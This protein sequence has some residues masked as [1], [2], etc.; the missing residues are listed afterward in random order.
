MNRQVP[1]PP[2]IAEALLRWFCSEEVV[3]TLLGDLYELH[4]KR[5][6]ALGKWR[7]DIYF[8]MEVVDLFRPFAWKKKHNLITNYR[9]LFKL[10]LKIARRHFLKQK[11]FTLINIFGL[12]LG[13]SSFLLILFYV[14]H[15]LSFDRFHVNSDQVFRVNCSFQDNAGNV[16]T[17]V[18]SPPALAPGIRGRF[19]ELEKI[20]RLRYTQNCLLSNEGVHFYEDRGYY[21]DSVFLEILQFE[22]LSGSPTTALVQPNSVVITEDMALKYFDDPAP[23]G[24][25]LLLN[26]TISLEVT[27]ILANLP[28]NSHLN[29]DFLI[30]FPTYIVPEG[31]ASDL[32]SWGW[33]G[34]LTYVKLQPNTDPEQFE[35]GL[36]NYFEELN[37]DDPSP[38][39]PI[40]QNMSDIYLGSVD[41]TDDLASHIRSGNRFSM[42]AL[43]IVAIL[44]LLIAGFNFSNLSQALSVNR[45]KS[46]GIRKVLGADGKS[47]VF[48]LVIE[49]L[50][51]TFFSLLLSI[52]FVYLVF[53]FVSRFANWEFYPGL[54]E[55]QK[56]VPVM[57]AAGI[58]IGILSSF[59]PALGFAKMN[60]VKSLKGTLKTE[61][62]SPLQF[63]NVLLT[64]QFAISIS[65]ICASLI[66]FKQINYLRNTDTGYTSENVVV[67]KTLPEDMSRFYKLYKD[68][69]VQHSSVLQV[70][71]SE[72][73]IG[74]PWPFSV[75]RNVDEGPEMNKRIFFNQV[76]YDYFTTMGVLMD[77]GRSFSKEY[78]NDSTQAIIVN[79]KA[80][81][82][83]ELENPIG[84]QVHFF[85]LDGPR[86]IVGVVEDFNYT[87]LHQELGPAAIILP[88]IDLEY[89][90]VRF[91]PGN[92]KN[93]IAILE[94][95]WQQ[96]T[97]GTPLEWKFMDADLE[98]LYHSEEKLSSMI[99]AFSILAILL[100]CLGLYGIVAFMVSKRIK[101]VGIRKVLGASVFSLYSLFIKTY[102]YQIMVATVVTLPLTHHLLNGW[103]ENFAYHIRIP[104][105]VYPTAALLLTLITLA[106]ITF[107]ILNAARVNPSRLIR[108]E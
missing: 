45:S 38:I 66:I 75:I 86:T 29:F 72:R 100:A 96:L 18:N 40:V 107:Q 73:V 16:T 77:S 70:S 62:R 93:Q 56:V 69:L 84:E 12:T 64:L 87:S 97:T 91:H 15:E 17:L 24:E 43:M 57:I 6:A 21:A 5:T 71:R 52:G 85:E 80:V 79:Q 67:I 61:T 28:A 33:L 53:P 58:F 2:G 44:V 50:L 47:I 106:A 39:R 23:L 34:F 78:M 31:Y 37:P 26:N 68:R 89:M 10:S 103:L 51:L 59:Y 35:A 25:T 36:A 7:A 65:L 3:E 55:I 32:S 108:Q 83:L 30:S 76:D 48:Q 90:Y 42:K 14:N 92:P 82:L 19:P 46:T 81:G 95:T 22:L 20:S 74:D 11:K 9:M 104:W 41:M 102:I 4:G 94:D 88:F 13:L 98:S 1:K 101:E 54:I 105:W 49:S 99:Q 8:F 60:V 27:G 63:K